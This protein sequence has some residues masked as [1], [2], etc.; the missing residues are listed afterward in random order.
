MFYH[1]FGETLAESNVRFFYGGGQ[2][3]IQATPDGCE[4]RNGV[5]RVNFAS[6]T[7]TRS[8]EGSLFVIDTN[9]RNRSLISCCRRCR[10]TTHARSYLFPFSRH[11]AARAATEK[12]TELV[13]ESRIQSTVPGYDREGIELPSTAARMDIVSGP[14]GRLFTEVEGACQKCTSGVLFIDGNKATLVNDWK[15]S[16]KIKV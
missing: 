3:L 1:S 5:C 12:T 2:T 16:D 15:R 13:A 6:R 10:T 11:G 9:W 4:R 14:V 7:S 8:S